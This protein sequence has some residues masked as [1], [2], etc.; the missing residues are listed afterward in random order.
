MGFQYGMKKGVRILQKTFDLYVEVVLLASLVS[1]SRDKQRTGV[2]KMHYLMVQGKH[3]LDEKAVNS[4][5]IQASKPLM[6]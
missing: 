4:A 3:G 5:M 2:F 6:E 1:T